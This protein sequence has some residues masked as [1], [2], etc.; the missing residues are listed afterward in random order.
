M[1]TFFK[2]FNNCEKEFSVYIK[3]QMSRFIYSLR[4]ANDMYYIG[5]STNPTRR[6]EEHFIGDGALFTKIHKPIEVISI[7]SNADDFDEDK[8]VK[9]F[10]AKYGIDNVRGGSYCNAKINDFQ[11]SFLSQEIKTAMNLCFVC[12]SKGHFAAQC[13]RRTF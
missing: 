1:R 6:I 8:H 11:K 7:I 10:M 3:Y 5:K 13:K 2:K 9:L 12:G 4:L